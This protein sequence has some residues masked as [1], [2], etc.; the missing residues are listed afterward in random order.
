MKEIIE[1][2]RDVVIQIATP[3]G[4]GTGFYLKDYN[5][6]VTNNHV[7]EGAKEAKIDGKRI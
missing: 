6:I 3:H 1:K 2:F 4:S 5:I 7:I